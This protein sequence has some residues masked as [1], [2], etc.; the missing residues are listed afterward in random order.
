MPL[1]EKEKWKRI[2]IVAVVVSPLIKKK[3]PNKNVLSFLLVSDLGQVKQTSEMANPKSIFCRGKANP[4]LP[5]YQMAEKPSYK[6]SL[7][8][9]SLPL[10]FPDI[11][12]L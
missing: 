4:S 12:S 6:S 3:A 7:Q 9:S 5:S 10:N 1:K 8:L 11:M 2:T